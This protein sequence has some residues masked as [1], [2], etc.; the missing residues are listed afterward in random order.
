MPLDRDNSSLKV[1]L[2]VVPG[3]I[4][5]PPVLASQPK[6]GVDEIAGG[7]VRSGCAEATVVAAITV[8]P[9]II[10]VRIAPS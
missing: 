5:K 2:P 4:A 8:K 10:A 1:V 9:P 3:G 6:F 7:A